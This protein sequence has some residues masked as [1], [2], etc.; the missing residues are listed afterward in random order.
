MKSLLSTDKQC[1]PNSWYALP[2]FFVSRD[3]NLSTDSSV[4]RQKISLAK[5]PTFHQIT[6]S[7]NFQPWCHYERGLVL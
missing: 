2:M 6:V 1:I 3:G 4:R 7:R 5:V